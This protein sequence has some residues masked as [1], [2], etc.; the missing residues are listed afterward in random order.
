MGVFF[1]F[2]LKPK[3]KQTN[4]QTKNHDTKI[5]HGQGASLVALLGKNL[6]VMQETQFYSWVGKIAWRRDSL[7][8]PVFWRIPWTEEPGRLWGRKESDTTEWFSLSHFNRPWKILCSEYGK[9]L[10]FTSSN[11]TDH[12]LLFWEYIWL[13]PRNSWDI[14]CP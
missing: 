14:Q 6:P 13:F 3:Q 8:I 7:P 5:I 11:L 12:I 9:D 2:T 1:L 10:I 4:K